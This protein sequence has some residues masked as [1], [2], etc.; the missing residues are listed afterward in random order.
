MSE[1]HKIVMIDDEPDLCLVMKENLENTGKFEVETL[2]DPQKAE[3]FVREHQPDVILMDIVMPTRQGPE[4]IE[5]LK[6]DADLKS[7]PII[8]VSGKGEMVYQ[9]KKDEFKWVP[10]TDLVKNRGELPD[11][12]GAEALSEAY[13]VVDYVSK[14]FSTEMVV[15][16]LEEVLARH[17]KPSE[18]SES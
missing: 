11:A 2:S 6:K 5:A 12:K 4:I 15:M 3:E 1:K 18:Q 10:N 14:P 13:G 17:K 9:R 8:I 7:I 16:I